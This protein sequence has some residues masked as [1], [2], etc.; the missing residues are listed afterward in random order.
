MDDPRDADALAR[1]IARVRGDAGLAAALGQAGRAFA[2]ARDW[3]ARAAV[4]EALY[5][6]AAG[7]AT[8]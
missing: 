4:Q 3:E 5:F 6:E 7:N 1:A 8:G 2:A